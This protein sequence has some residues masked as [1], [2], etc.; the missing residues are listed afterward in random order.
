MNKKDFYAITESPN[1]IGGRESVV[2]K[3]PKHLEHGLGPSVVK[4]FLPFVDYDSGVRNLRTPDQLEYLAAN[5]FCIGMSMEDLG[6]AVPRMHRVV[7]FP[8]PGKDHIHYNDGKRI[9]GVIMEELQGLREFRELSK[10]ERPKALDSFAY[11]IVKA[12]SGGLRPFDTYHLRNAMY[13]VEGN[14]HFFD[15]CQWDECELEAGEG[16][17]YLQE[18]YV[19][20]KDTW[21]E[22]GLR[23]AI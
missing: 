15:F 11:G 1:F 6:I 18:D 2:Y 21:K 17:K 22:L 7:N 16:M 12:I 10:N 19:L 9:P 20:P 3:L 5:E 13:D 23:M 4:L 14:A 8:S